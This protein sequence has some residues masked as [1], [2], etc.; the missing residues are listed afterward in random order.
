MEQDRSS[1]NSPS[2]VKTNFAVDIYLFKVNKRNARKRFEISSKLTIQ[3]TES[4]FTSFS[5]VSIVDFEQI[6]YC[7]TA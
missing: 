2:L 5:S 7:W 1:K 6:N 3:T 4:L